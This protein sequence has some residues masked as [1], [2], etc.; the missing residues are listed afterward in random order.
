MT[1]Q[2]SPN[3]VIYLILLVKLFRH[4]PLMFFRLSSNRYLFTDIINFTNQFLQKCNIEFTV[5]DVSECSSD[6]FLSLYHA[7]LGDF[8]TGFICSTQLNQ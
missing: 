4:V 8:P 3:L 2:N 6:L 1:Y 5:E 7:M